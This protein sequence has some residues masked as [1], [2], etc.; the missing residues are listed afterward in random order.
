MGVGKTLFRELGKVAED[1]DC[2][3]VEWCV[4][5]W[6][7]PALAFYEQTLRATRMEEW[8]TMRLDSSGIKRLQKLG[9]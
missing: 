7:A 9:L 3:R 6:N 5:T 4:L 2:Q 8:R 1:K